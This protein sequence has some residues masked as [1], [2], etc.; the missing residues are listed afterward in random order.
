[1]YISCIESKKIFTLRKSKKEIYLR[2][3]YQKASENFLKIICT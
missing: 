1:M 3:G 2:S